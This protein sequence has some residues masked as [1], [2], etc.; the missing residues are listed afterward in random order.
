[1]VPID[2]LYEMC[3]KVRAILTFPNNVQRVIARP[4][5]GQPGA[6]IRTGKRKDFSLPPPKDTLLDL[7]AKSGGEVIGIGKIEDI[8]SRR[9]ITISNHTTNNPDSVEAIIAA[10]SSGQGKLIFANLVDFD[11]LYG[12]RN[13]AMGYAHALEVF[14]SA[15][16]RILNAMNES[17]L[18]IITADHGCDPT[19]PST[20]HSREYVPLLV[21]GAHIR[22]GVNLG[23]RQSFSDITATLADLFNIK[24]ITCGTSF[25]QAITSL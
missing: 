2:D 10:L 8:F 19:T 7:I 11:M 15:L 25:A 4:F 3:R 16:P 6:F 21:Y 14:D 23:T 24:G 9:G 22:R 12:H 18:L 17:D 1:M 13:N 20:D 5:T